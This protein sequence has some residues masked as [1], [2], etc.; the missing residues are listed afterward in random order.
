MRAGVYL[1]ISED[2]S[3]E[4]LGAARQREDCLALCR[5]K[6]WT[7]TEY[8]DNDTS[9]TNGKPRPAY[10]RMLA[11]IR[12][13]RIKAVVAW[14]LDRLH[15]RPIEL[16]GFMAL[17]DEKHLAL[18]TVSGDVDLSTAQG[19]LVA[20][21]KGSVAAHET[22]HKVARQRRAGR[23]KAAT[24]APNWSR[25]FGYLDGTHQPDPAIAP[26]VKQAYAA[27]L[28]GASLGD[29]CR[30]WND[31]GALTVG[32]HMWRP[33]EVSK[34]LRKPRNAGLRTYGHTYGP[35]TR[36]AVVAKGD[37]PPL[38]DEE[39]FWA[40]QAALDATGRSPG[41]K[42]VRRHLLTGMLRCGRCNDGYLAGIPD[43]RKKLT[44]RCKNC[45]SLSIR[46]EHVEPLLYE[47][48]AGRLA[49]PDAVNLLRAEQHDTAE[50]EKLRTERATLLARL[51]EIADERADGLL[52]GKQAQRATDRIQENLAKIEARQQDQER[53][54]VFDGIPLGTAEVAEKIARLSP[55][56]FRAVLDVLM[57][58]VVMPVGK[59]G[60]IFN[61][62]RVKPN[63]R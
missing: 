41:R 3:G 2:R 38:V 11:D 44:Y 6:V 53:L 29:V 45:L 12:D 9:A 7:P 16:E 31:A 21:L 43:A 63:W 57:A 33:A 58:P 26:L 8:L 30:M 25:A 24:G 55:D 52:T 47:L 14:D 40:A 48:V 56:R 18:A 32:G 36:D 20:R 60:K 49:M 42:S 35:A 1:R 28:S 37:W 19:R 4:R 27:I 46:A 17:A 13:G 10:E 50:A 34:F 61:P 51:D 39:T 54:R 5:A 59:S 23:Q 62:D 15:R 22:E